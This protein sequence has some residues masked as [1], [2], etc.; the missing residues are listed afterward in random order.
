MGYLNR[1]Q[2]QRGFTLVELIIVV[3]VIA[4]LAAI[5]VLAYQGVRNRALDT[6]MEQDDESAYKLMANSYAINGY[7]D[8]NSLNSPALK[9][10]GG[11]VMTNASSGIA[12]NAIYTTT[13]TNPA[14]ND[15]YSVSIGGASNSNIPILQP[16]PYITTPLTGAEYDTGSCGPTPLYL[17]LPSSGGGSPSVSYQW[18]ILSAKNT[19]SGTWSNLSG[20]T[21]AIYSYSGPASFTYGDYQMYRVVYTANGNSV[22]SAPLKELVTNGC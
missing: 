22:T 20:A 8:F 10:A 18:Q 12:P 16:N 17:Y 4:I 1:A 6:A 7:Y 2:R 14:S 21:T 9:L 5:V 19:M 3:V 13:I 15:S 11:D